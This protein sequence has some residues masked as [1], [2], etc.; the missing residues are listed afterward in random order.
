MN[1]LEDTIKNVESF[2]RE[3]LRAFREWFE[4]F[5]ARIWDEDLERD[6]EAGKLDGMAAQALEDFKEGKCTEL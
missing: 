2:S 5:D 6:V 1:L 4:D 3:E